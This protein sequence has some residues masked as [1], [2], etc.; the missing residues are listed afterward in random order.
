MFYAAHTLE[1]QWIGCDIAILSVQLM[2]DALRK[3]YGLREGQHYEMSGIPASVEAA[4]ELFSRDPRQFQHWSV[5]LAGGFASTKHSGDLGIDGR[6]YFDTQDGLRNMALSVKGGKLN[7]SFVRELR[8]VLER[9]TDSEIGG[10]IC[11]QPP[12]KGMLSE[13]AAAGMYEYLGTPYPRLQIRT[14]E[15]LLAGKGFDTPSKVQTLD[16]VRQLP[17]GI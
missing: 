8:G 17:L 11:L 4:Q 7:P 12:T 3:R 9:E 2:R 6:V 1:R 16:W 15:D 14:I 10:F 5:E 13:A